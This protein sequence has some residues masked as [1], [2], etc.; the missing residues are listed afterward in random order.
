MKASPQKVTGQMP[1]AEQ[2][3]VALE[4]RNRL[5]TTLVVALCVLTPLPYLLGTAEPP[6]EQEFEVMR[7]RRLELLMDKEVVA[8]LKGM[9]TDRGKALAIFG[10]AGK[11][12]AAFV[13]TGSGSDFYLFQKDG[14]KIGAFFTR[15]DGSGGE[16]ELYNRNEKPVVALFTRS[17]GSGELQIFN[18][19]GIR[20]AELFAE[21]DGGR[22]R[23]LSPNWKVR[24]SVP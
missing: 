9:T 11:A 22:L 1:E 4:R 14:K 24:F 6:Q 21:R 18:H 12:L 20:V 8:T 5:L 17:D 10:P 15:S 7:V 3:L 2:R 23:I 19:D 16:L 13:A